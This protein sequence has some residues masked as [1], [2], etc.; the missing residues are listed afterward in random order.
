LASRIGKAFFSTGRALPV[1]IDSLINKSLLFRI[2][3]SAGTI[4]PAE[5]KIMSPGTISVISIS[6]L[7]LNFRL[8]RQLVLPF[9]SGL[10]QLCYF[11]IPE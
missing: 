4:S 11:G 3:Q 10:L 2:L 9:F 5:S 6:S 7:S 8:V 1:R